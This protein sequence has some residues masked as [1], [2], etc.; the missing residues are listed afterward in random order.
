MELKHAIAQLT[1]NAE[2]IKGMAEFVSQEQAQWKPDEESWSILETVTHLHDEEIEDFRVRL[3]YLLHKADEDWPPI[4]PIGWVA[5]RKYNERQL[6]DSLNGYLSER[7]KSLEWLRS[8]GSPDLETGK[9]APWG[10]M[11]AGDMLAA[12][13]AHDLLHM[14]QLVEILYAYEVENLR[15][16]SLRYAGEW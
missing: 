9:E 15:P 13:V 4:D 5:S 11:H 1:A 12:W 3:D 16:Y 6:E 14:R 2:R 8:L 7:E 10:I